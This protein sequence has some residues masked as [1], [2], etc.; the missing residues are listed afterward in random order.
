MEVLNIMFTIVPIFIGV[1]FVFV[2]IIIISLKFR[3]KMMSYQVKVT[4][5]MMEESIEDLKDI[6]DDMTYATHEV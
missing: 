2:I 3:G 4:K 6:S 1:V 5:Y